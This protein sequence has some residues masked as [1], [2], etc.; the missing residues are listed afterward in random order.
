MTTTLMLMHHCK[1]ALH[2]IDKIWEVMVDVVII[3]LNQTMIHMLRLSSPFHC[4][5]VLMMLKLT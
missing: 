2:I 3:F 5:L 4:S 1:D